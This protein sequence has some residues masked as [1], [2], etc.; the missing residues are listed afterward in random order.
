[1]LSAWA[2]LFGAVLV[3]LTLAEKPL[4]RLPLSPAVIYLGIGWSAAA[5]LGSPLDPASS[6]LADRAPALPLAIELAVLV[7]L[8][9]VGLRLRV[10]STIHAWSPALWLAV[11]GMAITVALGT[12]AAAWLLDLAWPA[13]LL[14]ASIAAPTDPVLASEVQIRSRADGDAVR[15]ALT[16][17]GGLNDGTA[18]PA[19]ML[20]LGWMGLHDLGEGGSRWLLHDVVWAIG[21]GLVIGVAL[22]HAVGAALKKRTLDGDPLLR[23]ELVYI[24]VLMLAFGLARLTSTSTFVVTFAAGAALLL[25]FRDAATAP[26]GRN[27]AQ[28]MDDFGA[29]VERVIEA[30]SVL[31]VGG[32]LYAVQ[33]G[34]R[35][36]V[37]GVLLAVIVRPI[38]V[39]AVLRRRS[40]LSSQR[41]LVAWFGIRGIGT[42]YYLAYALESGVS[43]STGGTLIQASLAAVAVSVLLHGISATPL[44][45]TYQRG[46]ASLA[47]RR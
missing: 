15:L 6:A 35:E 33:P 36:V 5:L 28:R 8:L 30:A 14:L 2:L 39:W 18:L 43:G 19:V 1:M 20:A 3:A 9:A 24:G 27:L 12:L 22:G 11:P 45:G 10:P 7:S 13:A 32:V 31:A 23:D 37:F 34:W 38:A 42:V 46:R 16:A 17:E 41:R 44:M 21:G 47:Q 4:R 29:R 26:E 25:P 40:M